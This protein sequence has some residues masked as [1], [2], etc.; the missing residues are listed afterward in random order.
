MDEQKDVCLWGVELNDDGTCPC[1]DDT[2]QS[3]EESDA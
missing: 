3:D 2:C 1:K